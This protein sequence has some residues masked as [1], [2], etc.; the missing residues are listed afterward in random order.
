MTHLLEVKGLKKHYQTSGSWLGRQAKTVY[1][2]DGVSLHV[3]AGETLSLIGESGC[4]KSTVGRSIL[5]LIEPTSGSIAVDGTVIGGL[6]KAQMHTV[7]EKMQA[8]F[9]DPF[10]SLNPRLSVGES[11]AEPLRNFEPSLTRA[12][13]AARV[14]ELLDLVRLPRDSGSRYPHEF[15]GGQRQRICIARAL[16]SRPKLIVCDEAVSALDVS[17]KAQ[18]VN[19]FQELQSS[20]KLGLLFISHDLGIVEHMTDRVAVMYLGRIVEEG[21]AEDVFASPQHPYTQ[22]LVSAI[23]GKGTLDERTILRGEVP[24]PMQ[25]PSG[26]H[27]H[28]RC[29][30]AMEACRSRTPQLQVTPQGSQV[31]CHLHDH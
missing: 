28:T 22:A 31:A 8:V 7:R 30:H 15:S 21:R 29:P 20:L 13:R 17:V 4:G 26:C 27:F 24:S 19:L 2:V 3:G 16:A 5:G 12:Q 18:I 23:P 14:A 11:I 25:P 10:A 1:A 6:S 9:Q